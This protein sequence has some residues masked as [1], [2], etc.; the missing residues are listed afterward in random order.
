[1]FYYSGVAKQV[2]KIGK[3]IQAFSR[4]LVEL[5]FETLY[6]NFLRQKQVV[7]RSA[8]LAPSIVSTAWDIRMGP[9]RLRLV[10]ATEWAET[11][12]SA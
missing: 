6:G 3:E 7:F 11:S 9:V 2:L 12:C 10:T 8:P 4:I 5:S 1:M